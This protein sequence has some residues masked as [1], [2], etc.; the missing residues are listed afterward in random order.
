M[1]KCA[2][3]KILT[4]SGTKILPHAFILVLIKETVK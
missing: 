1:I 2:F 3:Y 4:Q